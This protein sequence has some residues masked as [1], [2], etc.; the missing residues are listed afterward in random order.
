MQEF[1]DSF[2]PY[3]TWP[4]WGSNGPAM[5]TKTVQK[6]NQSNLKSGI[7]WWEFTSWKISC[8]KL[9]LVPW[10]RIYPIHWSENATI[11]NRHIDAME[12]VELIDKMY[13]QYHSLMVELKVTDRVEQDTL[14]AWLMQQSCPILFKALIKSNE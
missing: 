10:T 11:M 6:C 7:N 14:V 5:V 9:N 1:V 13:N 4:L 3:T 8:M 12:S 2:E